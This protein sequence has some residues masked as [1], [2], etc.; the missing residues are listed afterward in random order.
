MSCFILPDGLC[1]EIDSMMANFFWSGDDFRRGLHWVNWK[2][3]CR[4]KYDGGLGFR[5]FKAFNLSLVE[6]NWW[7][8][9]SRPETLVA[10]VFKAVYFPRGSMWNAKRGYRPSYAWTS[11]LR[12]K[13]VFEKGGGWRIRDGKQVHV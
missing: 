7:R 5:D 10:Q 1:A 12:T 6:K 3:M 8:L 9:Y 4:H 2:Q 13:W 11:I